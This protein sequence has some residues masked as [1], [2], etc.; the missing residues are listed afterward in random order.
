MRCFSRWYTARWRRRY[1]EQIVE[2]LSHRSMGLSA[3]VRSGLPT[4]PKPLVG[5][6]NVLFPSDRWHEIPD[7]LSGK[8]FP[9][10][11]SLRLRL[12]ASWPA[13]RLGLVVAMAKNK[14]ASIYKRSCNTPKK[15]CEAAPAR[16]EPLLKSWSVTPN[17][18]WLLASGVRVPSF[19]GARC[20]M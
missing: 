8:K 9:V 2:L 12:V 18:S 19:E 20:P 5:K 7:P 3:K 17:H 1:P 4:H 10:T 16:C 14:V 6:P 11:K 15:I 13:H